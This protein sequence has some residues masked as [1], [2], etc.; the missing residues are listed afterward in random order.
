LSVLRTF[1]AVDLLRNLYEDD[2]T[3]L[4][5]VESDPQEAEMMR[6]TVSCSWLA[7]QPVDKEVR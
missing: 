6:G 2:L 5:F 1:S 7:R 3:H 4:L